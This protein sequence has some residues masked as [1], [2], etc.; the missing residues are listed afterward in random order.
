MKSMKL[1]V[2][3]IMICSLLIACTNSN[4]NGE[5]PGS[6]N[7]PSEE[8]PANDPAV[9]DDGTET[10]DI[11]IMTPAWGGGGME[12]DHPVL[13]KLEEELNINLDIEWAPAPEYREKTSVLAASNNFPDVYVIDFN[14]FLKY[15]DQGI[16]LDVKPLLDQY[17]NL[18][19]NSSE[20]YLQIGNPADHYY[21]LTWYVHPTRDSIVIR[22]DWL[23]H[24]G[25]QMPDT[26]DEFY[27]VAKAFA[28][29]DPN[30]SGQN[31]TV[32]FSFSVDPNT[33]TFQAIPYIEGAF[34]LANGWKD[35]DG[36]LVPKQV[37]TEELKAFIGFL[38]KA[39]EEGVLDKDFAVLKRNELAEKFRSNKLGIGAAR[40]EVADTTFIKPLTDLVP[41]ATI[42]Q[43]VPP[44]GPNG[45]R[46]SE[47]FSPADRKVVI[48]A[49]IDEK[50]QHRILRLLDYM[51]SE[52]GAD[53]LKHG[54]EDIHYTKVSDDVYEKLPAYD[55][56]RP[57]LFGEW[58]FK[59]EGVGFWKWDSEEL[60]EKANSW[61][62]VNA[63][64]EWQNEGLGLISET[65]NRAGAE[66]NTVFMQT[67]IEIIV[68]RQ[69][70][71]AVEQA[72]ATWKS[73]GGDQ[74]I[75]EMNEA[76]AELK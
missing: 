51:V 50:K 74:I 17:P 23:D 43:M 25:L 12:D 70:L 54:I 5:T 65:N 32:G 39:Y 41:E 29:Q 21:G 20:E 26:I 7:S 24:L 19:Q 72:V 57:Q 75:Q 45:D 69:P 71:D 59:P 44:A 33:A 62:E 15:R 37:Q 52:E 66:I 30:Q 8:T 14:D 73:N 35:I 6:G 10:L 31:D 55:E 18:Q 46:A 4:T 63:A 53:M 11:R 3:L 28:L 38:R 2:L 1:T 49:K 48:N 56:E 36:E 34:G 42:T 68:G 9:I 64:Y 60:V 16:F 40:P 61:Y 13:L 58:F 76:Y 27:E 47:T 22:Q 67:M